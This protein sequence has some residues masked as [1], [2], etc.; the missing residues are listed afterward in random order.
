MGGR[1]GKPS[2]WSTTFRSGVS[3]SIVRGVTPS[4]ARR[5]ART[6]ASVED[7]NAAR[8]GRSACASTSTAMARNGQPASTSTSGSGTLACA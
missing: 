3:I 6:P 8:Q 7:W 5:A 2:S 1:R 4:P